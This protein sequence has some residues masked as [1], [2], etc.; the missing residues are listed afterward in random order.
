MSIRTKL[1]TLFTAGQGVALGLPDLTAGDDPIKLF[2]EWY[3]AA[4]ES[5]MLLPETTT[6]ATSNREGRPSARAVLLKK[7]SDRGFVFFTNYGSRKAKELDENP[8]AALL[9][10]W[11]ILERQVRVEGRVERISE[12]ESASYFRTRAR[13]SRIGAWASYQSEPLADRTDLARR[14]QK[15]EQRFAGQDIPLPPFWGG[16]RVTPELIEFWQGRVNRLHDRISY[17]QT[18]DGWHTERLWP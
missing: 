4:E 14:V 16:Y 7:W 1:K 2:G 12:E 18:D 5:G 10:H 3:R 15:I 9:F 13:G 11:P 6:L 8:F 17:R